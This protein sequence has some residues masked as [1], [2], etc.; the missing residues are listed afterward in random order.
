MAPGARLLQDRANVVVEAHALGSQ[1]RETKTHKNQNEPYSAQDA[2]YFTPLLLGGDSTRE[3]E[4]A[5]SGHV[6][7]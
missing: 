2:R 7:P 3:K 6:A 1:Q 4:K 5:G